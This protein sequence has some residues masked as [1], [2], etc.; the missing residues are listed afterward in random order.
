[1]LHA[2]AGRGPARVD[3]GRDGRAA[4]RLP[5]ERRGALTKSKGRSQSD[6]G[7]PARLRDTLGLLGWLRLPNTRAAGGGRRKVC[8]D[9][10]AARTAPKGLPGFIGA[11]APASKRR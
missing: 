10:S 7:R 9:E 2:V 8:F 1:M 6:G 5:A 3:Q 4:L 11:P